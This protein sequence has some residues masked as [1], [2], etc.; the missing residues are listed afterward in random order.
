MSEGGGDAGSRCKSNL[1]VVKS[2]NLSNAHIGCPRVRA[3]APGPGYR[4]TCRALCRS[5]AALRSVFELA[6]GR[7]RARPGNIA[8]VLE[9]A[10]G[11]HTSDS[12]GIVCLRGSDIEIARREVSMARCAKAAAWRPARLQTKANTLAVWLLRLGQIRE[13]HT[14]DTGTLVLVQGLPPPPRAL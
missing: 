10:S 6:C 9:H 7:P 4:S 5:V 13:F 3:S 14:Q 11:S 12:I 2:K 8:G 1:E